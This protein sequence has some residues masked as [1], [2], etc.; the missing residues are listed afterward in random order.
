MKLDGSG[1]KQL[2]HN[3]DGGWSYESPDGKTIY[4]TGIN[5]GIWKIPSKGGTRSTLF[6]EKYLDVNVVKDGLYL[7]K[8]NHINKYNSLQFQDFKSNKIKTILNN[9][10]FAMD[11]SK[12]ERFIIYSKIDKPNA[13]LDIIENMWQ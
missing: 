2:T 7:L 11:V 6:D 4:I 8:F 3:N 9:F 5:G 13:D 12:D 10:G 1:Q